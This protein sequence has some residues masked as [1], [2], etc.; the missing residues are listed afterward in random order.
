MANGV[1]HSGLQRVLELDKEDLGLG[2]AWPRLPDLIASLLQPVAERDRELLV[3]VESSQ[4]HQCKAELSGVKSPHMYVRKHRGPDGVLR[5]RAAHLPTTQE[6][7]S[8]ESDRHKAMKEFLARTGQAAGLEVHVEKATKNRTSRP[9]VTIVG[10]GGVS[11]G[12][13]A[14]YYNASAGTVLRR[15]RAHAE[16]GLVANWITHDD[17]FHLIDRSNWMLTR[18]MTWREISDAADLVLVGGFRMLVEWQCTASA[19]RPCPASRVKTGCGKVHLQWDTPRRLDDEGTGWTGFGGN[20]QAVTVGQTLIGAATGSVA[21]LFASSRKDRR[22]GAYMWVPVNDRIRWTDYR[23]EEAPG[24]EEEHPPEEGIHFSGRDADTACTFGE[25]TFVPSAPLERRGIYGVELTLTV[26]APAPHRDGASHG[27]SLTPS[28][29]RGSQPSRQLGSTSDP[30][31]QPLIPAQ[32]LAPAAETVDPDPAGGLAPTPTTHKVEP[33]QNGLPTSLI[34]LQRAADLERRKL[35]LLEPSDERTQQRRIW[36]EAAAAV[37][38]A[39]T[40]YA[41]TE[42]QNRFDV[43]LQLRR[44]TR[45]DDRGSR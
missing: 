22:S 23:R 28:T 15:A 3:C 37:Q 26:D 38:N 45:G 13:E 17:R 40:H 42:R 32:P 16:A 39:V 34:A 4:G 10:A 7:T 41:R 1:W 31:P 6:M 14:Q 19:E 25:D 43:E 35:E 21:P 12:C 44:A 33:S 20:T 24:P 11:L 18:P 29:G 2:N 36:R 9:D 30:T 5:L 8:E 27:E